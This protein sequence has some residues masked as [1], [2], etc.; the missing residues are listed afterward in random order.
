MNKLKHEV[1]RRLPAQWVSG[2]SLVC[3]AAMLSA[4]GGGNSAATEEAV[5]DADVT[6]RKVDSNAARSS[7]RV[8]L[9][10]T[11]LSSASRRS[12]DAWL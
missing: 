7:T 2:L 11:R 4:C 5:S 3:A 12:G 10:V 8:R 9:V 1:V 6:V